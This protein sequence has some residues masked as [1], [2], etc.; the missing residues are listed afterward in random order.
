MQLPAHVPRSRPT[1]RGVP[2]LRGDAGAQALD[3][4]ITQCGSA[5]DRVGIPAFWVPARRDLVMQLL[6]G[7]VAAVLN[8]FSDSAPQVVTQKAESK[9]KRC[10]CSKRSKIWSKSNGG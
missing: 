4:R 1:V 6:V 2:A 5:L 7:S 10:I 9:Q 8:V 3:R